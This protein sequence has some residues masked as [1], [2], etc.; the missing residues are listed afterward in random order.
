MIVQKKNCKGFPSFLLLKNFK[1]AFVGTIELRSSRHYRHRR[2][3]YRRRRCSRSN[4]E[5]NEKRC[6]RQNVNQGKQMIYQS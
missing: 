1:T 5:N 4:V 6:K 3:R 2:H